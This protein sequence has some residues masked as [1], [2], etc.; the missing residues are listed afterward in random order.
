MDLIS[1]A[2]L[3]DEH[4][5]KA[6]SSPQGRSAHTVVGGRTRTL[7]HLLLALKAGEELADHE[8][9]GEATLLVLRGRVALGT[10]TDE[11]TLAQLELLEIPDERHHVRAL[12]DSV[13]VLTVAK[14]VD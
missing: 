13:V 5:E 10:G 2:Q 14:R 12:E 3:G 6:G 7:R 4:L 11:A 1:L 9:P 8:A